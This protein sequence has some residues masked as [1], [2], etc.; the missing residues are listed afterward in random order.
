[1]SKKFVKVETNASEF[2]IERG[3]YPKIYLENKAENNRANQELKA[4]LE[5]ILGE[6]IAIA[7]GHHSERKQIE[8]VLSKKEFERELYGED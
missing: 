2:K 5:K 8:T 7:S 4:R 3:T 1:M 6:K